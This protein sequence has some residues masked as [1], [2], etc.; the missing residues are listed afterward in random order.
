MHVEVEIK[1]VDGDG[2]YLR[3]FIGAASFCAGGLAWVTDSS[4]DNYVKI[5]GCGETPVGVWSVTL[6]SLNPGGT[7]ATAEIT[8]SPP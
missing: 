6:D 5:S 3:V 8:I 4:G 1:C 7:P 2:W